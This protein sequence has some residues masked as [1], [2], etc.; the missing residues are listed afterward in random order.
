MIEI[1]D[2]VN[3][4]HWSVNKKNQPRKL[5]IVIEHMVPKPI[6]HISCFD[7]PTHLGSR[8][9]VAWVDGSGLQWVNTSDLKKESQ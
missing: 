3:H 9:K 2:L 6:K 7:G 1:G 4:K 8:T 5:G